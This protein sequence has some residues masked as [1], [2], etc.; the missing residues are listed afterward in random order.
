MSKAEDQKLAIGPTS[1]K[2][3][4][5]ILTER[6]IAWYDCLGAAGDKIEGGVL[7]GLIYIVKEDA[8]YAASLAT[9]WD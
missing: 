8:A 1:L 3:M 6:K 5:S 2:I 4:S 9:M 7:A